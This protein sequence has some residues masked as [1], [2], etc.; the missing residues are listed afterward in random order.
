MEFDLIANS[1]PGG[2]LALKA[3]CSRFSL[4]PNEALSYQFLVDGESPQSLS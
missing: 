2:E 1:L 3:L 4:L